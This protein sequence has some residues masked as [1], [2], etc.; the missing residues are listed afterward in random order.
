MTDCKNCDTTLEPTPMGSEYYCTE[1]NLWYGAIEV[2]VMDLM[3]DIGGT[4]EPRNPD[5]YCTECGSDEDTGGQPAVCDECRGGGDDVVE[6]NF[7]FF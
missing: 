7:P 4:S 6:F 3:N 2:R 5:Y 1:C